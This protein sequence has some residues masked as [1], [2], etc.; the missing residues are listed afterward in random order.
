MDRSVECSSKAAGGSTIRPGG[1]WSEMDIEKGW[2]DLSAE[3]ETGTARYAPT[4]PNID[5]VFGFAKSANKKKAVTAA[6]PRCT[7]KPPPRS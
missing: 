4:G 2:W 7:K 3:C 5:H 1:R 6:S